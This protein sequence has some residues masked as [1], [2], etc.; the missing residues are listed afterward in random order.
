MNYFIISDTHFWH[1]FM[2]DIGIRKKRFEEK[3]LKQLKLLPP[4][5]IL[6]HLWDICIGMDQYRHDIIKQIPLRKILVKGNHDRKTY[7]WYLEH[8]RDFVCDVFTIDLY[9]KKIIFSHEPILNHWY[10]INIHWHM[11]VKFD[12]DIGR[13]NKWR[14]YS[15]EAENYVPKKLTHEFLHSITI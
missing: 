1:E 11:H 15:A 10:D 6:I 7:G 13:E 5:T 8:W 4:D 12:R 3:I 9:S 14:C 2:L